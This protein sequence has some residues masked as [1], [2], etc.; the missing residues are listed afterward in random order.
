M[1]D[2]AQAT[3]Q[4]QL[5]IANVKQE[6]DLM[7]AIE[8][9]A[10]QQ[11]TGRPRRL[12]MGTV[13]MDELTQ[14]LETLS[15]LEFEYGTSSLQRLQYVVSLPPEELIKGESICFLY[16]QV[17][18]LRRSFEKMRD[19]S[20]ILH[21]REKNLREKLEMDTRTTF[22]KNLPEYV[23]RVVNATN[24]DLEVSQKCFTILFFFVVNF[25]FGFCNSHCV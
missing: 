23:K 10:R 2:N 11:T 4:E 16:A 5:R 13:A 12:S 19:D 15:T 3:E 8:E 18:H 20:R 24:D 22:E 14:K 17:Y 6:Q 21:L 25:L 1:A 9:L 7:R